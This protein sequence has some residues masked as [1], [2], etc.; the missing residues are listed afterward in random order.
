MQLILYP[1]NRVDLSVTRDYVGE[2]FY[3]MPNAN[4]VLCMLDVGVLKD[5]L[6]ECL[7]SN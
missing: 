1:P 7:E 3:T 2:A 5:L 4:Q 6:R